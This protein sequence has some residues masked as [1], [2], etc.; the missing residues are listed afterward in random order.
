MHSEKKKSAKY[1]GELVSTDLGVFKNH[2]ARNGTCYVQT[3]TDHA[4]K[5]VTVYGLK[6]KSEALEN[7]KKYIASDSK[8]LGDS[9]KHY[10]ADGAGEL[11]GRDTLEYLDSAGISYSWSLTDTPEMNSM[12]ERKWRTLNEM[13]RCLLMRLGLPTDFWWDAYEAAVWIH[14]RTP[15][16]TARGWMTPYE[17]IHGEAPDISNLRIWGCKTYVRRPRDALRIDWGDTTRTGYLIGYSETPL[18]Y[19]VYIP[20]LRTEM[21]SVHCIFDEVIPDR[22]NEYFQ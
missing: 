4:S 15:T 19:R 2:A 1:V 22:V 7:L 11:V 6:K 16:K 20:E 5:Y 17:F 8:K 18:G 12:T 13:T 10:H 9:V 21:I 3:S 14:N